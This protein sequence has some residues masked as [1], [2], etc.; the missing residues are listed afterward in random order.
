MEFYVADRVI[1]SSAMGTLSR[2]SLARLSTRLTSA[3]NPVPGLPRLNCEADVR[4]KR[5]ALTPDEFAKL[6]ESVEK[7]EKSEHL[8]FPAYCQLS[9]ES[10]DEL[11]RNDATG[12]GTIAAYIFKTYGRG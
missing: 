10:Q 5:R 9:G 12:Y 8:R 11:R 6:V 1:P 4:Q 7:G 2:A 3:S